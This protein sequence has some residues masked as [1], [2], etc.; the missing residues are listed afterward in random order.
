MLLAMPSSG[1][2]PETSPLPREVNTNY[3]LVIAVYLRENFIKY[4]L[5]SAK[6]SA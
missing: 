1:L 4:Y 5:T 3:I 6:I 2:E